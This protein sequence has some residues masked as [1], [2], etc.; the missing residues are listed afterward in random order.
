MIPTSNKTTSQV[1]KTI[2]KMLQNNAGTVD[3]S[4]ATEQLE[5][6]YNYIIRYIDSE[7]NALS[8][9]VCSNSIAKKI[10]D[11]L[12]RPPDTVSTCKALR[13]FK[14]AL[15]LVDSFRQAKQAS[16]QKSVIS[17]S[18]D[19]SLYHLKTPVINHLCSHC[20]LLIVFCRLITDCLIQL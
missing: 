6:S 10:S 15:G 3:W 9:K 18:G 17:Q 16:L 5:R 8:K 14:H 7:A 13:L 12:P 1:L 19:N 11:G 20:C 4:K 2:E